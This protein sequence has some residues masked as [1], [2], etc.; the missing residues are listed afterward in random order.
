[1]P[2]CRP[3]AAIITPPLFFIDIELIIFRRQPPIRHFRWPLS[4]TP[5]F[6]LLIR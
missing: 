2:R 5:L 6:S 3:L 1:M 4:I